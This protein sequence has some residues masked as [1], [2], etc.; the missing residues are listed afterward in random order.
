MTAIKKRY[1]KPA[2]K[3]YGPVAGLTLGVS[4]TPIQQGK[5]A[6][7]GACPDFHAYTLRGESP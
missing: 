6:K 3:P 1:T 2:L 4:T 5:Q 7:A